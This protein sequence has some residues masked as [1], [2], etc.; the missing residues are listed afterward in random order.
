MYVYIATSVHIFTIQTAWT[1]LQ[2]PST[3]IQIY[4][5]Y[6]NA[7]KFTYRWLSAWLQ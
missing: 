5:A 7:Q 2:I 6:M 3:Y 4:V 1:G